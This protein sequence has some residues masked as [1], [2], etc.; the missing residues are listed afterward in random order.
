MSK[1]QIQKT[2]SAGQVLTKEQKRFNSLVKK[3]KSLR[4]LIEEVKDI[5]LY[6]R[7]EGEKRVKPVEVAY[8]T[9]H[10]DLV[11]A[12]HN[13]PHR[14]KLK[15]KQEE[16]F[17]MM[18]LEEI[19]YILDSV[20]FADD[21]LLKQLYGEYSDTGQTYDEI[22]QEQ[23]KAAKAAATEMANSMFGM[24]LNEE[25]MDDPEKIFEKVHA[26][27]AEMDAKKQASAEKKAQRKKTDKQIE[28]EQKRAAAESAVKKS[29]KQIYTELVKY[30]HPDREQDEVRRAEKSEIMKQITAAY[31]ADDHLKLLELQMTLLSKEENVFAAFDDSQL[32]YF[33]QELQKQAR[34]LEEEAYH[35]SPEGNGNPYAMLYT[36]YGRSAIDYEI[37]QHI[38]RQKNGEKEMREFI[39]DIQNLN[40]FKNFIKDY[41][42]EEDGF[43]LLDML[44]FFKR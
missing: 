41:Q 9:S 3:I 37:K 31:E 34:E 16:K 26:R 18:M 27:K 28:A 20:T 13:S 7:T 38:K 22:Q 19:S 23:I 42:L 12:L 1:L 17:R 35:L 14:A 24:D 30:F 32:K 15:G 25:D 36:P 43:D 44:Q 40:G 21:E 5:D 4:E 6:L 11:E 8:L 2:A 33:N 10:R 29:V 39:K